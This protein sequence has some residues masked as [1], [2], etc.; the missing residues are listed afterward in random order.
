MRK[1]PVTTYRMVYED[2]VEQVPYQVCR[3][4][5]EPQTIRVPHCVEK[6]IPVTYTYNV[7]RLVCYRV[8]LDSCGQPLTGPALQTVAA[9]PAAG[10]VLPMLPVAAAAAAPRADARPP[11]RRCERQ[12][13][14]SRRRPAPAGTDGEAASPPMEKAPRRGRPAARRHLRRE[15]RDAR[16]DA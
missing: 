5:A 14:A 8:P 16:I 7:S 1:V 12:A 2:R 13:G 4:V 3:M 15:A 11:A 6:R 10:R 9:A